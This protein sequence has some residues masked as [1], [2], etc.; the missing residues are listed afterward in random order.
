MFLIS[1]ARNP[2]KHLS[3]PFGEE[4]IEFNAHRVFSLKTVTQMVE[5]R[6]RLVSFACVDDAGDLQTNAKLEELL[7]KNSLAAFSL[8][9]F[10]LQKT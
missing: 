1:F 2:A 10:E 9:I 5:A 6:F 3:A 4:R 7:T 8:A